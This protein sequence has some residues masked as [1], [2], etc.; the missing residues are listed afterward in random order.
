MT[1]IR[2]LARLLL[3]TGVAVLPLLHGADPLTITTP[4]T[5]LSGLVGSDYI[6]ALAAT[7]GAP[8]YS[9]GVQSGSLPA[10]LSL[11]ASGVITGTPMSAG[12][13]SFTAGVLD[14]AGASANRAFTLIVIG[15]TALL[16]SG[17]LSH[18]AAGGGWSS[19][20]SL[21]NSSAATVVVR[22]VLHNDDGNNMALPVTATQGGTS[23]TVT[24]S[25]FDRV[26]NP[27]TTLVLEMGS[28]VAVT[29]V[30]WADV[31]SSS[32]ISGYAIFRQTM[33]SGLSSEGTVPLQ[34]QFPL[35]M[36]LAYDDTAGSLMGVAIANLSTSAVI[37]TV[38]I[39]DDSGNQIDTQALNIPGNGH[40]SFVLP[41]QFAST[42][43][44]RGIIRF[45]S[46][47]GGLSGLGL[48]FSAF[49]TFTSVPSIQP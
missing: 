43:L 49:G 3:L 1:H 25:V 6:Q 7:G 44:K 27:Y 40:K 36:T 33:A 45:Q 13:A 21:V 11:S 30:G 2:S 15:Q 35:T 14:S 20:I 31:L 32:A 18:I 16:R 48:R 5:L 19:S 41:T 39:W 10:G 42:T 4:G 8:P 12:T 46:P 17:V 24:G 28:Q 29:Q 47:S 9:W 37:L 38:S 23:Q 34:S 22:V 26:V